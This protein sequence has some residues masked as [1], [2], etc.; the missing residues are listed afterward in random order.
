MWSCTRPPP[1]LDYGR[2]PELAEALRSRFEKSTIRRLAARRCS[3]G[4]LQLGMGRR[5]PPI[6]KR[7]PA[8]SI[9]GK[10]EDIIRSLLHPSPVGILAE[11]STGSRARARAAAPRTHYCCFDEPSRVLHEA[12]ASAAR[13]SSI[14]LGAVVGLLAPFGCVSGFRCSNGSG[15]PERAVAERPPRRQEASRALSRLGTFS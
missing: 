1:R 13:I 9:E 3:E 7:L 15:M 11:R 14:C 4:R 10:T 2:R 6:D 5:S 12:S 8:E